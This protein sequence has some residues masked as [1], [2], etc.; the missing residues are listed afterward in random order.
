[1]GRL[2]GLLF[3]TVIIL[4]RVIVSVCVIVPKNMWLYCRTD[5]CCL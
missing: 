4:N 1:M 3:F 5:V 2:D